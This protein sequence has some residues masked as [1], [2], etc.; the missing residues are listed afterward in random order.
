MADVKVLTIKDVKIR[1]WRWWSDW[2][3]IAV[4]DYAGEGHLFQMSINRYK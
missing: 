4:F 3:D 1:K 2:I